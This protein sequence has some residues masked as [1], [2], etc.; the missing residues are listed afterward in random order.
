VHVLS[1]EP[2]EAEL[3]NGRIDGP[4]VQ[5]LLR[6]LVPPDGVDAWLLCGPYA[7]VEDVR[8]TLLAAGVPPPR[9]T[10]SSSTSR[11]RRPSA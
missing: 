8:A 10:P 1:R 5:A 4:K 9:C 2:Q 6:T 7:M 3:L 11:T